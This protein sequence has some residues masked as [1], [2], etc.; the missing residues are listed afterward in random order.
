MSIS[1]SWYASY[2]NSVK[3]EW[4]I[5]LQ[6]AINKKDWSMVKNLLTSMKSFYFSE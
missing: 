2:A 3:K 6:H 4:E 5:K 1:S